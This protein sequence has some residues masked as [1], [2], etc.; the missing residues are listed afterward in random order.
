MAGS[1]RRRGSDSWQ[2]VVYRGYDTK[3]HKRR[4]ATRTFRGTKREA[5]RALAAFVTEAALGK[6]LPLDS[7]SV[8]QVLARW[9][10]YR[11][12]HLAPSTADRYRVAIKLL[13]ESITKMPIAKLRSLQIEDISADLVT[14]GQSGSSIRKLHWA[15]RQSL[16]WAHKRGLTT[17]VATSGVELPPLR[18]KKIQP[19][20]SKDVRKVINHLLDES[21]DWG[22]LIAFVAWTGCRR[23]EVC[24]LKWEDVDLAAGSV[25]IHRSVIREAGGVAERTTKTGE[26][27]RIAIGP[28]TTRILSEHL[29]RCA[30]RAEFSGSTISPESFVFSSEPDGARPYHPHTITRTFVAAC[31]AAGVPRMRLHDLRHHSATTLL[32]QGATV[33]E[34]MDRHGWKTVE[35]VN[36]YRHHMKAKDL[37]SAIVLEEA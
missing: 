2:L 4:N 18:A 20:E 1:L 32:K 24:G 22:A 14:A 10:E 12:A 11:S 33:G 35:M 29:Q 16:A 15:L 37:A 8:A 34:V 26:S 19:P 17:S 7:T 25:F 21:P 6:E 5:E 13:P 28:K 3:A 23:G 30:D 31:S 27:R 9:L 36:R